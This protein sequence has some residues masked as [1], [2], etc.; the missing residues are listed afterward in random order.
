[1]DE[2]KSA[3]EQK[4]KERTTELAENNGKL[5]K[6]TTHINELKQAIKEQEFSVDDIHKMESELKGL[7]EASDRAFAIRDQKRKMLLASEKELVTVCNDLDSMTADYNGKIAELQLVPDL[8]SNF[9]KMKA[10]VDKSK[11]LE[12]DQ[13]QML[14]VDLVG[15]VQQ[16]A[17]SSKQDYLDKVDRAKA[18]YQDFLDQ[19]NH[20][21]DACK[22]AN[23]K[24]K[25]AEDKKSK[26]EQTLESERKTLEAKLAVRE[27]EV[28]AM[29]T[30]IA[31][32]QDPVALEEQMAAFE[33]QCAELE[34]LRIEHQEE[35]IGKHRAVLAEV[36]SACQLMADHDAY[37]RQS[38]AEVNAYW[39]QKIAQIGDIVVPS[40]IELG[41]E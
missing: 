37:L 9:A 36:N 24:L 5:D 23:A 29:E 12:S 33:R 11:L 15:T 18:Q 8:G 14:G 41:D 34:A 10:E 2:H 13:S 17:F 7:S 20:A 28:Q 4:V 3:L 26:C 27:R 32:L 40:N 19:M 16:I 39:R 25:I 35:N 6:M 21:D 38:V 22:E 1:M 30:K 31:A